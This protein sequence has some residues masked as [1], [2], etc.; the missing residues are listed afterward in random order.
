MMKFHHVKFQHLNPTSGL[1]FPLRLSTLIVWGWVCIGLTGFSSEP[2]TLDPGTDSSAQQIDFR[3]HVA[4]I[5]RAHCVSCH[6]KDRSGGLRLTN[7]KEALLAADS[8]EVAILPGHAKSSPLIARVSSDDPS[9]RMPPE[10]AGLSA[11]QVETLKHWIDQGAAWPAN[12]AE[13]THWAYVAPQRP[14]IPRVKQFKWPSNP[15]DNFVLARLEAEQLGPSQPAEKTRL[16]RRVY[17]DLIGLPPTVEEVEAFLADRRPDAYQRVVDELLSRPAYGERWARPWLDLARYA[18][19]NGYQRDGFR[20]IWAYRDWVIRAINDDLPFDQ[21]S[22]EQIA[23]DLLPQAT[24]AQK[25]ATGFHRCPTV[26]VEAGVDQETNRINAVIDRVNTTATVWLGTTLACAQCHNHKYDPLTQRD[27]YR[28]LAYFNNTKMETAFRNQND[29]A[30]I[31]FIGPKM[32][33][34]MSPQKLKRRQQLTETKLRLQQRLKGQIQQSLQDLP[35]WQSQVLQ[36]GKAKL[37]PQVRRALESLANRQASRQAR[38]SDPTSRRSSNNQKKSAPKDG[39]S[40][41]Q[42]NAIEEAFLKTRPQV[43]KLRQQLKGVNKQ[44]VALK[45]ETTL[46]MVEE[47]QPR[48]T[49]IFLRGDHQNPGEEVQP[50]V[51]AVLH[52]LPDSSPKNRLGLARW[53]VSPKNPLVGRVTVNRW[54]AEFFG[55]GLVSTL[56]DFGSQGEAPTHPQL[57]DWL[58]VE[59]MEQGW[60]RKHIHRLIVTSST[61]RQSSRLGFQLHNQDPQ[62]HLLARGPRFRLDAETIRD[63]ALAISGLLSRKLGGPPIKPPQPANFWRVTGLVDNSY[64][65]S[66]GEDRY[67]RGIYVIWRRS[68]PYPSLTNFDAP[69]RAACVVQRA[70][71]NTPRQAL[72]LL[73]DPVYVEFA[74]AF[75]R[76]VLI[77]GPPD[78][79]NQRLR[80][81]FRVCLARE[82]TSPEQELLLAVYEKQ[83]KRY[84]ANQQQAERLRGSMK[85]PA[86]ILLHEWAAWFHLTSIL[87][88]LDETITKS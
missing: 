73:N 6:G 47:K 32:T 11:E 33:L 87:L 42:K 39:L 62:N 25:I 29:T 18:D 86:D 24:T 84:Q 37:A 77:E 2:R 31:D 9:L 34:P 76:R 40:A 13:R 35:V 10:G 48:Q 64:R 43:V 3:Q 88:N 50:G 14:A 83:L 71:T 30:A 12:P 41:S 70:R 21:F 69:D 55:R 15:I 75:A 17:L 16:L 28:L 46:V 22:I 20:D 57:L 61:Y 53:L 27:Y 67:R 7:R 68:A 5:F 54:W 51:P 63:N 79:C 82:P 4:P 72:T 45:P 52:A 26:N 58:A 59:L 74:K 56:E 85:L 1:E 80:Y 66:T 49:H 78:D 36:D 8:G 19:S 44:L 81:A 65:Q 38:A 23:G 60:S